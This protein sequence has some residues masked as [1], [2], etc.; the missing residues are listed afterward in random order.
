MAGRREQRGTGERDTS[1][2]EV[3]MK[4][5]QAGCMDGLTASWG[6][7]AGIANVHVCRVYVGW[8]VCVRV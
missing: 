5:C 4:R 3:N 2:E 8:G 7:C 1:K 6:G